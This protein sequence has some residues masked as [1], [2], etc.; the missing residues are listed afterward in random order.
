MA[1]SSNFNFIY[2]CRGQ[3]VSVGDLGPG[4]P[5]SIPSLGVAVV[6]ECPY[7]QG[8][9]PSLKLVCLPKAHELVNCRC[10]IIEIMLKNCLKHQLNRHIRA[11]VGGIKGERKTVRIFKAV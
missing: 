1:E 7:R 11:K 5:G 9:F 4:V 3:V 8:T 6:M 2:L 10:Y